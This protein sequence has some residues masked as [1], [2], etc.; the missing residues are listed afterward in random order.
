[1]CLE[2]RN[3]GSNSHMGRRRNH[4][5]YWSEELTE[6]WN[7]MRE[8]ERDYLTCHTSREQINVLRGGNSNKP[9]GHTIGWKYIALTL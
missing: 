6:F 4:K 2:S 9:K 3:V 1:M 7:D 5:P 8:T